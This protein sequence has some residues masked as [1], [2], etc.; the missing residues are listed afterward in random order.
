MNDIHSTAIVSPDAV[1]GDN[2]KIGP[3]AIVEG[4]ARV[5][6]GC[7]IEAHARVCG[8]ARLG[9]NCRVGSFA[10]VGGEPQDIHFDSSIKSYAEIGEGTVLR[11]S[12][13]VHRAT[14][15]GKSTIVGKNCFLMASAHV[16]HDCVVG[17][18]VIIANF[19]A[20]A[21]HVVAANDIFI[22][23]GVMIHQR[24]RIGEGVIVSGNSAASFD[25][26]PYTIEYGRNQIGGLNLIGMNR[27]KMPRADIAEVKHLYNLVYATASARKNALAL[28]EQGA[29]QTEAGK[30]FLD[31]FT[32]PNRHYN[33]PRGE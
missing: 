24:V 20:L 3:Y 30:K 33:I 4:G 11:E 5:G 21:G 23:G 2:I 28:I 27:R 14:F 8:A 31:F 26:P 22:S 6:D 18:N 17:D 29:A 1:L 19:S 10:L 25:I 16:G 15:E 12:S 32:M 9:A 7:A 13:T